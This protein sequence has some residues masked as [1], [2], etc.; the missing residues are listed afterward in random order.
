MSRLFA[1]A[2][3]LLATTVAPVSARQDPAPV[4]QAVEHWLAVQS[5][6]L[7]GVASFEIGGL[8]PANQLAPCRNFEVSRPAAAQSWGRSNVAVRCLDAAGWRI[9]LPVT[10]RV[11]ADYLVSARPIAQGQTIAEGDLAAQSGDLADL[12]ANIL[13]D[14]A[15]AIGK[16]AGS[17]IPAGRPLRADMLRAAL[18]VRQNQSVKVV[19]RG[20]G[21]AVANEGRALNQAAAGQVVQVRLGGG[22][23]VSGIARD[24]GTVEIAY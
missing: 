1:L 6:G 14:P 24:D 21:F 5:Q 11:Q 10:I 4:R 7:P 23:V 8:D 22:R 9:H 18:V 19:S 15:L 17:S 16:T 13:L 3:F 2:L 12:P 20:P